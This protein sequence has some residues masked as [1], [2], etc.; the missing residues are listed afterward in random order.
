MRILYRADQTAVVAFD[1]GEFST[2]LDA[3]ISLGVADAGRIKQCRSMGFVP[4]ARFTVPV[5]QVF[6]EWFHPWV[7]EETEI[8]ALSA[9][10]E[11]CVEDLRKH[12]GV[13]LY[14]WN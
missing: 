4:L 13:P 11:D 12:L 10:R 7:S 8:L 2:F 14:R 3:L 9:A 1:E 5:D 6:P